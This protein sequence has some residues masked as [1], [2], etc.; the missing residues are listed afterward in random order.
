MIFMQYI[1]WEKVQPI[2]LETFDPLT[3]QFPLML[4][5]HELEAEKRDDY[6]TLNGHG[7]GKVN[8]QD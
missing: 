7:H 5:L 2:S 1:Y 4:N 8:N 3:R 6:D